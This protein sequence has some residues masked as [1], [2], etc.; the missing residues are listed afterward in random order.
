[1]V[2]N[3]AAP[4]AALAPRAIAIARSRLP[5]ALIPA[6]TAPHSNPAGRDA[7]NSALSFIPL[8][9]QAG[10]T[11]RF[12]S[13][14]NPRSRSAT[15][16]RILGLNQQE[17]MR[18]AAA[19]L[20]QTGRMNS[21]GCSPRNPPFESC[22]GQ[23][24][25][26]QKKEMTMKITRVLMSTI[27][28]VAIA[29]ALVMT[30]VAAYAQETD[31]ATQ[32]QGPV[33]APAAPPPIP[34]Y[35]QPEAPGDGYMWTPGY[36]S[37]GPDGYNWMDGAWVEP[38]YEGALWTPG[39]WGFGFGD[40]MWYPGYWG[41]GIGYYGGINYGFGYFGRGFYGGFWGGGR[42]YGNRAYNN[43]GGNY[44]HSYNQA[45]GGFNGR[46]GGGQSFSRG[47]VSNRGGMG[48]GAAN[49]GSG[50]NGRTVGSRGASAY[51]GG[52][53]GYGNAPV[54]RGYS[55]GRSYGGGARSYSGGGGSYSGGRSYGGGARSYSGGA[56]SYSGGGGGFGGGGGRGGG[57]G[58][59][60][61]GRR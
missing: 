3:M 61:G 54:A 16:W 39:Y 23:A 42:F 50:I 14:D 15:K 44:G 11:L 18:A 21:S 47:G 56:R 22:T 55:G 7:V 12:R 25:D 8:L 38:P 10:G 24:K 27:L 28:A 35:A 17:F 51:S 31:Q 19:R 37:Y 36:W 59:G 49:R 45:Y 2:V 6:R 29:G 48:N 30:T 46:A 13:M 26:R 58:G 4:T 32:G 40:Y 34:D 5:L 57:G 41:L 33:T 60:G 53:R 43:M 52:A 20:T 1:L 9:Y